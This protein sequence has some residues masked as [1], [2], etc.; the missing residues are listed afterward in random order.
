MDLIRC[1]VC[2]CAAAAGPK[3][4]AIHCREGKLDFGSLAAATGWP[5][6]QDQTG[7]VLRCCAAVQGQ[8]MA[9]ACATGLASAVYGAQLRQHTVKQ[10]NTHT[11]CDICSVKSGRRFATLQ[12]H[13]LSA[14]R[15]VFQLLLL[16]LMLCWLPWVDPSYS[17]GV[18]YSLSCVAFTGAPVGQL[19]HLSTLLIELLLLLRLWSL[20]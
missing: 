8:G 5:G 9:A 16:L 18:A 15:P 10:V 19:R 4:H 2:V 17:T 6:F 11:P 3:H 13:L 14:M 1:N 7:G 12:A 20:F